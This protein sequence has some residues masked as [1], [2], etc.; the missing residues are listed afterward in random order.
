MQELQQAKV[1][2]SYVYL[3]RGLP[4]PPKNVGSGKTR[5]E[6]LKELEDI[7]PAERARMNELYFGN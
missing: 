5:E 2:G 6:V 4:V 7:T 3:Q 1:D